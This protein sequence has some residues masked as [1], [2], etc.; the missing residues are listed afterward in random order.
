MTLEGHGD[1][2]IVY[3]EPYGRIEVFHN[4]F[5][6]LTFCFY[7]DEQDFEPHSSLALKAN[8]TLKPVRQRIG[9]LRG[10]P[11]HAR[12]AKLRSEL[13]ELMTRSTRTLGAPDTDSVK[14]HSQ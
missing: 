13:M 3:A 1:R 2:I 5:Q 8:G 10:E 9:I 14:T 12:G 7:R 6:G 4:L 11:L